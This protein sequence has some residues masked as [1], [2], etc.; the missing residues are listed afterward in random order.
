MTSARHQG[1]EGA[2][3]VETEEWPSRQAAQ[4]MNSEYGNPHDSDAS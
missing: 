3:G 1:W 2:E 4:K